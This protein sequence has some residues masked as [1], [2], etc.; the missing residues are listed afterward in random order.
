MPKNDKPIIAILHLSDIHI[1]ERANPI[2][3][4]VNAVAA[5][6]RAEA[7]KLDA[8]FIVLSGDI[9]FSGLEHEYSIANRLLLDLH[10]KITS[11]H[12]T[13]Q[14]EF[15][16]VPGNHD[17]DFQHSSDL[18]ELAIENIS[19]LDELD[20]DGDI[21]HSCLSV[22]DE[23]FKFSKAFTGHLPSAT[24]RLYRESEYEV[25]THKIRFHLYNTAWVSR[26]HES[27]GTL[28]YPV[29]VASEADSPSRPVD[30]AVSVL[31][32]P[33]NWLEPGNARSLRSL[34]ERTSDVIL[35][36]HEH[37]PGRFSRSSDTGTR[38]DHVEGADLAPHFRT[39]FRAN[40]G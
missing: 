19:N 38:V 17:C 30:V 39:T 11:D 15:I 20:V 40:V 29:S 26:L 32:H 25:G 24:E 12:S 33:L 1:C 14:V 16:V 6:L 4:R 31:H 21:V 3:T 37:V 35:T 18:R 9:A 34:L 8:C 2:T 7:M 28:Y 36:G 27:P 10:Q 22:Q 23:F 13:A 5:A